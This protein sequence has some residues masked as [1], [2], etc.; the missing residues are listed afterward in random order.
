MVKDIRVTK[1][2]N[3]LKARSLANIALTASKRHPRIIDQ[4]CQKYGL[5]RKACFNAEEELQIDYLELRKTQNKAWALQQ[6]R[7]GILLAKSNDLQGAKKKYDVAIELDDN[8]V[9]AYVGRGCAYG[10]EKKLKLA[11]EDLRMALDIDPHHKNAQ[12]YLDTLLAKQK[13]K[14]QSKKDSQKRLLEGEYLLP[15]TYNPSSNIVEV[16]VDGSEISKKKA[17]ARD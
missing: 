8:C 17:R 3:S 6:A 15:N 9:E 14:K 1:I 11:I 10:N 13:K 4:L 7:E 5:D 12:Y 2:E 16:Q